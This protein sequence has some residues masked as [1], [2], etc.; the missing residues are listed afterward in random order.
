MTPPP[1]TRGLAAGWSCA[2]SKVFLGLHSYKK[3]FQM[4]F[5]ESARETWLI[6][7]QPDIVVSSTA[8]E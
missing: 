5:L 7:N 2:V 3:R 6:V 8:S 4:L 1:S